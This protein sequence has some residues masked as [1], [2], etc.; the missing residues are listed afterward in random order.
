MDEIIM[1][2]LA[3]YPERTLPVESIFLTLNG[4]DR[5]LRVEIPYLFP[6]PRIDETGATI[7][8]SVVRRYP[9]RSAVNMTAQIAPEI[10]AE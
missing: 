4:R 5:I 10:L 1:S 6:W 3:L 8:T 2:P 9:C 7:R